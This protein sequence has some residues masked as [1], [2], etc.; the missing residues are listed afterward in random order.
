WSQPLFEQLVHGRDGN[1]AR[2]LT[3][4]SVL[5]NNPGPR[6]GTQIAATTLALP[7]W[8]GRSEFAGIRLFSPLPRVTIA[9]AALLLVL[10]VCAFG[11]W[12]T[13]RRWGD[14]AAAL[15]TAGTAVGI[16]WVAAIRSP[17]SSFFGLSSDYVRWLWPASVF[18]WFA[19]G[20]AA[21][22]MLCAHIPM[23]VDHRMRT[24]GAALAILAVSLA[25]VPG[26]T[27]LDAQSEFDELRHQAIEL[28]DDVSS[29]V[30]SRA[31]LYRPPPGYDVYGVPLLAQLQSDGIEFFV[32]DPVLV[33]QFGERRRYRGQA[34]PEVRVVTAMDAVDAQSDANT[35]A[36]ISALSADD[37]EELQA[38]TLEIAT[39]L[40]DGKIT[41]SEAGRSAVAAGF[42]DAWLS[43]LGD[44]ELDATTISRSTALAASIQ[45]GLLDAEPRVL[46]ALQRFASLRQSVETSTVAVLLV[47]PDQVAPGTVEVAP[48]AVEVAPGSNR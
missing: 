11:C 25:N 45:S 31:V 19:A 6:L 46:D 14:A 44:P 37:R 15:L 12:W 35:I 21:W 43:Q 48:S 2:M 32:D 18:I 47:P 40:L 30:D 10:V 8:W 23:I 29:R 33:R 16:A 20:L 3:A 17:M 4:S 41:L 13:W 27:S 38:E 7:P 26:H 9:T 22:R 39:W 28:I 42:G 36:F 5:G 34:L 24:I 1:M